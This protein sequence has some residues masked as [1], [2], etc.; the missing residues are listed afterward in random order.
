MYKRQSIN[1]AK[2]STYGAK[3][4]IPNDEEVEYRRRQLEQQYPGSNSSFIESLLVAYF[5]DST[6]M[7][8]AVG[9]DILGAAVGDM[10]NNDDNQQDP[11]FD[12]GFGGG[13][14]SGAGAG[15]DFTTPDDNTQNDNFS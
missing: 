12:G 1:I 13:G 10:L 2:N 3:G 7:G 5:T 8:T 11:S 14:F 9:G 6:F 4:Y 15:G